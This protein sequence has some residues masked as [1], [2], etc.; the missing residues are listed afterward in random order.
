MHNDEMAKLD[1]VL[2]ALLLYQQGLRKRG[3][4]D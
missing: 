4:N 2:Q 1:G 3:L